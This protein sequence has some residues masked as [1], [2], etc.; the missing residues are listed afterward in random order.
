[1]S[2]LTL[3]QL[4]DGPDARRE[5]AELYQLDERL[6]SA[7]LDDADRSA[8]SADE[9]TAADAA[10]DSIQRFMALASA[11]VD[12]RLA[13]RGYALPLSASRFAVLTVWS[14][15]IA[16]YH[17]HRQR[18]RTSEETGRIERDY[19]DALRAL[20]QIAAGKLS[21]G[22]GDPLFLDGNASADTGAVQMSSEP[23]LFSRRQ[24]RGL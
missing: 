1:M 20:E 14:R 5:L 22:A 21:L 6:F 3:A 4:T 17:L 15:S 16:R 2:Y 18:D 8:W 9:V 7:T 12:A 13:V 11:E 10:I 24:L 19:R 23:R